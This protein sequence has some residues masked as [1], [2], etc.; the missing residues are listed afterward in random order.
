L[1]VEL[2]KGM[3]RKGAMHSLV[4]LLA[5]ELLEHIKEHEP[6]HTDRWVPAADIK[7]ALDLNFV[8]VPR[9]NKQY[10]EKGWLFAI[11]ARILEDERLVQYKKVGSRAF[12]R[13]RKA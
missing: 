5:F 4:H 11:L 12:Y 9:E 3:N 10:G 7:S 1:D 8:A 6:S 2:E 13:S